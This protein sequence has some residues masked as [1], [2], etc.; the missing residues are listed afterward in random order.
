MNPRH[1]RL[2]KYMGLTALLLVWFVPKASAQE[3]NCQVTVNHQQITGSDKGIYDVFKTSVE[4]FMNQTQWTQMR[5]QPNEKIDCNL[6]FVFKTRNE[7]EHSCELQIQSNRP[8]YGST[9]KT[10]LLNTRLNITF[11]YT[12]NQT[13]VFNQT[14]IDQN[15]TATLAF[16][17]YVMLGL[18]SDSFSPMGG[19]VFF[20]QAQ[21][22]VQLAQGSLGELW[23]GQEDRNHWGWISD[24]VDENQSQMRQLSYAYHRNGLDRMHQDVNQARAEITKQLDVLKVVKQQKPR[25]PIL[26]NFLDTKADELANIYSKAEISEKRRVHVLLS[27]IYPASSNRIQPI[28]S[29]K[30]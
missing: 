7:S 28:M 16:W 17:A 11:E 14:M 3:F 26:A 13:L 2:I 8:V 20:Q 9:L 24:L 10:S 4:S 30:E 22:I 23:K 19:T 15:L 5:L 12:E 29:R 1:R 18:D 27:D 25:S 6:M 21:N